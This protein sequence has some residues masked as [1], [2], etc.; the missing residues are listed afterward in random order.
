LL[1]N[2]SDAFVKRLNSQALGETL[3][4]IH[5]IVFCFFLRQNQQEIGNNCR[6]KVCILGVWERS[7]HSFTSE[8]VVIVPKRKRQ[9][10]I[11]EPCIPRLSFDVQ[12]NCTKLCPLGLKVRDP[13]QKISH[14]FLR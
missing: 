1:C 2:R 13:G 4:G 8:F 7:E 9:R 10:R 3:K 11:D 6:T 12:A 5:C 14:L